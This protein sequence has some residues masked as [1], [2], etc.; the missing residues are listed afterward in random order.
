L[1]ADYPARSAAGPESSPA[2]AAAAGPGRVVR[3]W[4]DDQMI[5]LVNR[6]EAGFRRRRPD[7][8][9][10]NRLMGSDTGLAG[11]YTGVAD[12]ALLGRDI[13]PVETMAFAWIY[14]RHPL[15]VEVATGSLEDPG[16][17]PALAV[18]V[19]VGNPLTGLTLAQL[20]AIFGCEL[21]R[22]AA[23]PFHTWG[24]LGLGGAWAQRP[25]HAC[26]RD[27][28]SGTAGFFR[29]V[30]LQG[31]RK[32]DWDNVA[33]FQDRRLPDGTVVGAD[34]QIAA[35]VARDPGGIGISSLGGG[36]AGVKILALAGDDGGKGVAPTRQSLTDRSYPLTRTIGAYLNRSPGRPVDPAVRAF[37][38]Y[39]LGEAGQ[40]D[41]AGDGGFLPLPPGVAR[42]QGKL[43]E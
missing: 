22:G 43:L 10:E 5:G 7:L 3:I 32:W 39:V 6:W 25:I 13:S 18:L 24:D 36:G 2:A 30:V 37:L 20:D 14:R 40:A 4:G 42:E 27:V 29:Q 21:R 26:I 1:E 23:H 33:E 31:S 28:D 9:F 17:S 34:A 41:V 16:K 8:R 38:E 19:P 35:A 11:L 12:L 15:A